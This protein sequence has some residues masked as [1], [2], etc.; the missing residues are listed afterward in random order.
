M[1][2]GR[3]IVGFFDR[4]FAAT[5]YLVRCTE[6]HPGLLVESSKI[7]RRGYRKQEMHWAGKIQPNHTK[8]QGW[9][10]TLNGWRWMHADMHVNADG[11]S[12]PA[13]D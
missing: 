11:L 7:S 4:T 10:V 9:M 13:S 8:M 6:R 5:E 12:K 1:I 3:S 2:R